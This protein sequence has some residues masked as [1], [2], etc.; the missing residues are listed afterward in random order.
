[1]RRPIIYTPEAA[2][3]LQPLCHE[4]LGLEA[5]LAKHP[6]QDEGQP[7]SIKVRPG[8]VMRVQPTQQET[9]V[10]DKH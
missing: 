6:G 9:L 3:L 7:F 10:V 4:C 5:K 8:L 2:K 1:M